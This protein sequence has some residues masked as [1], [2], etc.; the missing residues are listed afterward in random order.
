M[1][2]KALTAVIQKADL[3]G[4]STRSVDDLV[5]ALGIAGISK[6][7]VSRP[8][9]EIDERVQAFLTPRSKATCPPVR[10]DA[11]NVKVRRDHRIVSVAAVVAV[12]VNTVGRREVPGKPS[13]K[14]RPSRSDG[15]PAQPV[16]TRSARRQARR[17]GCP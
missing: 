13:A 7:Q 2:E 1:A 16:Q 6:C 4:L 3:Q 10:L 11:T 17:L 8:C 14:A 12:A 15:R 5:K 9:G